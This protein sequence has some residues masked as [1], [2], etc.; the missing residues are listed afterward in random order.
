MAVC[1]FVCLWMNTGRGRGGNGGG[2]GCRPLNAAR[3]AAARLAA[4]R[5]GPKVTESEAAAK[6]MNRGCVF[7]CFLSVLL[8]AMVAGVVILTAGVMPCDARQEA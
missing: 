8:R 4:A 1:N 3:P 5:N 7:D 2:A 6:I